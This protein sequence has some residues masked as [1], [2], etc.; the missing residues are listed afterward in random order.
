MKI[1]LTDNIY[2]IKKNSIIYATFFDCKE[3]FI[4]KGSSHGK[5]SVKKFLDSVDLNTIK[6]VDSLDKRIFIE[7]IF[8]VEHVGI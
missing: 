2:Y 4:S 8:E 7:V 6:E 1:K 3:I 5:T